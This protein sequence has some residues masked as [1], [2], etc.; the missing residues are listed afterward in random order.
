[1][2]A[3]SKIHAWHDMQFSNLNLMVKD[4]INEVRLNPITGSSGGTLSQLGSSLVRLF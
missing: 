4:Q 3:M 1:M 2:N